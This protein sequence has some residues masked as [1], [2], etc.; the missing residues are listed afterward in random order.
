MWGILWKTNR[1]RFQPRFFI[2]FFGAWVGIFVMQ[3][4]GMELGIWLGFGFGSWELGFGSREYIW[5]FLGG[6]GRV[7]PETMNEMNE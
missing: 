4:F 1:S 6:N 3:G 2:F 5:L 7:V